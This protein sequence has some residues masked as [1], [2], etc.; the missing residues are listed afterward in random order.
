MKRPD[1]SIAMA[2]YNGGRFV[3]EQ[4]RSLAGQSLPPT[5]LVVTDDGST[6]G[7][8]E[9]IEAF[10]ASAP[11]SIRVHR[12][13][14]RLGVLRNFEK[15][16]SLCSGDIVFLS[17]QDDVW[18]PEKIAEVV[19]AFEAHP[20]A[21]V[22]LNDKM[23]TDENLVPSGSTMLANIRGFGSPDNCFVAGC[24][25]AFR[26]QWL[27][28]ALPIPEGPPAHDSWL[29]GLAHRLEKVRII[30]RPLQFYRRHSANVSQNSYSADRKVTL[31]DR[32]KV[33]LLGG[34]KTAPE[35]YWHT[36][37]DWH[38]AEADRIRDRAARLGIVETED[39]A[40]QA[41]AE[42]DRQVEAEKARLHIAKLPRHRRPGSVW[43]L[44]KSGGYNLFTGWKS[45]LKDLLR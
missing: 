16:L 13:A 38:K 31:L 35:A 5:E 2:T 45:V 3:S 21:L 4:L 43:R 24:C 40:A 10:A 17:D 26:R 41:L 15:A 30:E 25:A 27:D 28:F 33:E 42:I 37:L 8:P 12:N 32:A 1:I 22:I 29:L 39:G 20:E 7:T 9:L 34:G 14:E 19:A 18:M 6:D 44:W 36:F 23:I 11:F